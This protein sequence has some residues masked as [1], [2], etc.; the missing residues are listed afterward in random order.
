MREGTHNESVDKLAAAKAG[1][2][3]RSRG[4][5]RKCA[6]GGS[7]GMSGDCESCQ[8]KRLTLQRYSRERTT[9]AGL[10]PSLGKSLVPT[11]PDS[12]G[13]RGNGL[14]HHFGLIKSRVPRQV[15]TKPAVSEPTD[16]YEQEADRAAEQIGGKSALEA[17]PQPSSLSHSE[18]LI[19]RAV[20]KGATTSA[21]NAAGSA[22]TEPS[23]APPVPATSQAA[24]PEAAPEA[25][26]ESSAP[27][28][29]IVEDDA[30]EVGPGQMRKSAFLDQ[31]RNDA[32]AAADEELAAV[33]QTTE[34]CPYVERWIT[35]Y[36]T[37]STQQIERALRLYAPEA[38]NV[39]SAADYIPLVAARI[40]RGVAVW[41][42]TGQITG[43][44]AELASELG[45]GGM[46]GAV[47]GLLSGAASVASGVLGG[48]GGA[49]G[50][51]FTKAKGGGA[52]ETDN[53][54]QLRA[55]LSG[56]QSLDGGART[57]MESAFGYD[58]SRVRVH[59]DS[60]AAALS[61]SLN[62]RAFT[63]GND[64]AFGAGEYQPGTLVGD[65][66]LAHEL[67]H[68]VQQ[69]EG[70]SPDRLSQKGAST[71][72]GLEEDADHSAVRAVV[73]IWSGAKRGLSNVGK[74]AM[75]HLRS[76]LRLSRCKSGEDKTAGANKNIDG[77]DLGPTDA[78]KM[79]CRKGNFKETYTVGLNSTTAATANSVIEFEGDSGTKDSKTCACDCGFLRQYIKGYWKRGASGDKKYSVK[80]CGKD[81]TMNETT[82]IEE[83]MA[84]D[85]QADKC[86]QRFTDNPGWSSGLSNG[87]YIELVYNF[88]FELWDSCQGKAE[89][90][91]FKTATLKG[92]TAPR[93]ITWT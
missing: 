58:F 89:T 5:Q 64:V 52:R 56:G 35:Q 57:R 70:V 79:F 61:S 60:G 19:Q 48:I 29:L 7:A 24:G 49:L 10:L 47:G 2:A 81:L 41:A 66:L 68:V 6:C 21:D 92:D 54:A 16:Q 50:G 14:G 20:S 12:R 31:L 59:N 88:K 28:G 93:T 63:I 83:Y 13:A 90:T 25:G 78:S 39:S 8:G 43:V 15:Q 71:S 76:G 33:G 62:A 80:S 84:C 9:I 32:C 74:E 26:A 22:S 38:A 30:Q 53:P 18:Q 86:K 42:T 23:A 4:V 87:D 3:S 75:P 37:R 11:A 72:D 69:G 45:G 82:W 1:L 44:P 40:R 67:A 91:T 27:A 55:Q 34:G 17:K 36:R 73:S 85:P 51:I 46:L 65:A 77:V